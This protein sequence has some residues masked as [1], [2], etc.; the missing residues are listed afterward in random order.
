[1]PGSGPAH[2]VDRTLISHRA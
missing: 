2:V 1:M